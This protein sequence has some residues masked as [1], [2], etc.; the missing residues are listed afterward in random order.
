MNRVTAPQARKQLEAAKV[1]TQQGIR[2]VPMPVINDS[3]YD[4]LVREMQLKIDAITELTESERK[5][6]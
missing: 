6:D 2:F 4:D 3:D 1:M 5:N